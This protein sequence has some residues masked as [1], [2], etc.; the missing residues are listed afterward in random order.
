LAER[1]PRSAVTA[2]TAAIAAVRNAWT[3]VSLVATT[4]TAV[5]RHRAGRR[6]SATNLCN[7][8]L[9]R[10]VGNRPSPHSARRVVSCRHP[11]FRVW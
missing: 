10:A 7:P 1:S 4:V 6:T 11:S 5:P 2:S 9:L 3:I 8:W